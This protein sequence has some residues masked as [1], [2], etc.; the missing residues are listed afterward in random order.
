MFSNFLEQAV[1]Q[2]LHLVRL[3]STQLR[4]AHPSPRPHLDLRSQLVNKEPKMNFRRED[5][6]SEAESN[7]LTCLSSLRNSR[8]PERPQHSARGPGPVCTPSWVE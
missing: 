4:C 7:G 1:L 5:W 8:Q 2:A 3:S 6:S